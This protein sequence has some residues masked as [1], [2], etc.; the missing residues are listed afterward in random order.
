MY[1][2]L[3]DIYFISYVGINNEYSLRINILPCI[4]CYYL[5]KSSANIQEIINIY[6]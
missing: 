6:Y 5:N 1:V 4:Y 2:L 3:T